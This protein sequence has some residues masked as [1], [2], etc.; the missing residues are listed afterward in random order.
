MSELWAVFHYD[1]YAESN[2]LGIFESRDAAERLAA[3]AREAESRYFT[4]VLNDEW[5]G[6]V[7]AV[8]LI[9]GNYLKTSAMIYWENQAKSPTNSA[10]GKDGI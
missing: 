8:L 3:E 4:E 6:N 9:P 7:S 1:G 2:F 5:E 10:T